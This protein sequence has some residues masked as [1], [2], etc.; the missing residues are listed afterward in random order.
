MG[1]HINLYDRETKTL[2]TCLPS[3]GWRRRGTEEDIVSGSIAER[4][5]PCRPVTTLQNWPKGDGQK[6]R[7][8]HW[9]KRP[10]SSV[11]S[12]RILT[13]FLGHIRNRKFCGPQVA[14]SPV[15]STSHFLTLPLALMI[16][17]FPDN[18]QRQPWSPTSPL[19]TPALQIPLLSLG[20]A[21][22]PLTHILFLLP[23]APNSTNQA[24]FPLWP[25]MAQYET[26]FDS[27]LS[28]VL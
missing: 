13:H 21:H 1:R 10:A 9:T 18:N 7:D 27:S 2:S 22:N 6:G 4:R 25:V 17:C 8:S 19:L 11:C 28:R 3:R 5:Q 20:K 24:I 23:V 16:P 15:V 14:Y 12:T 26:S